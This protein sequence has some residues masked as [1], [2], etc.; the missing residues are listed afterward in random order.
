M[1]SFRVNPEMLH[2]L[3]G[4]FGELA[5]DFELL[6]AAGFDLVETGDA[7]LT[8]AIERFVEQSRGGLGE[9]LQQFGQL[10][11]V[12]TAAALGYDRVETHV[13]AEVTQ[14]LV[15]GGGTVALPFRGDQASQ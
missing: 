11:H 12:L 7:S 8:N 4:R 2:G 5:S 13:D 6:G 9:L 1:P 3:A 10:Q 14:N 15:S